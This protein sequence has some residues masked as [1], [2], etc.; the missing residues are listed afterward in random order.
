MVHHLD[1]FWARRGEPNVLM[2]HYADLKADLGGHMRALAERLGITVAP[3][4]WPTLVQAATFEDMRS[5]ATELAPQT[6]SAYWKDDSRFFNRG[7]SGQWRDFFTPADQARYEAA[8][9][10]LAS[11]ELR[12]WLER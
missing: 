7:E 8:I 3:D 11:P 1:T 5:R 9:R 4:R 6:T 12:S 2:L 10:P